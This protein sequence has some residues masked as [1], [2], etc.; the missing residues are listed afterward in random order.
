ISI[1][2]SAPLTRAGRRSRLSRRL[3]GGSAR[4]GGLLLPATAVA[5]AFTTFP[6][7]SAAATATLRALAATAAAGGPLLRLLC[8]PPR[9]A[10][11]RLAL[12]DPDLH[13]DPA[14]G[15]TGLVEAVVDVG[16]ERVQG[17]LALTVELRARHLGATEAAAA[18]N[19]DPLGAAL[20]G[21]LDR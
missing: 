12:V 13:A 20:H 17:H 16:A 7:T 6:T 11:G 18:L 14:E 21:A 4:G 15:R 10:G 19:L 9:A 8:L 1:G 3:L 5:A 2:G